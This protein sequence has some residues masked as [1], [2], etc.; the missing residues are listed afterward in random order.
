MPF[1]FS[2]M[3]IPILD[4]KVSHNRTVPSEIKVSSIS[5]I[6]LTILLDAMGSFVTVRYGPGELGYLGR[7]SEI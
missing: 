4:M 6:P 1:Q 7:A 5:L 3:A 2:I